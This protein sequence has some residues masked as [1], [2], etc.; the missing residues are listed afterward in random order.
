MSLGVGDMLLAQQARRPKSFAP[1]GHTQIT[2]EDFAVDKDLRFFRDHEHTLPLTHPFISEVY[3]L[4][5]DVQFRTG[6]L[7]TELN[8]EREMFVTLCETFPEMS[9]KAV[10]Y[11]LVISMNIVKYS[12]RINYIKNNVY[13]KVECAKNVLSKTP[14]FQPVSMALV[15]N[16]FPELF[17]KPETDLQMYEDY[18]F[19]KAKAKVKELVLEL[20]MKYI[21]IVRAES[22]MVIDS[23]PDILATLFDNH[24]V[25]WRSDYNPQTMSTVYTFQTESE[26]MGDYIPQAIK[27]MAEENGCTV[28]PTSSTILNAIESNS[29]VLELEIVPQALKLGGSKAKQE[30]EDQEASTPRPLKITR[31]TAF[32]DTSQGPSPLKI[33]PQ[34]WDAPLNYTPSAVMKPRVQFEGFK[35]SKEEILAIV[36]GLPDNDVEVIISLFSKISCTDYERT[37]PEIGLKHQET[38]ACIPEHLNTVVPKNGVV[39][40]SIEA[41][42]SIKELIEGIQIKKEESFFGKMFGKKAITVEETKK[43]IHLKTRDLRGKVSELEEINNIVT[44]IKV[45]LEN[46]R[47]G[48]SQNYSLIKVLKSKAKNVDILLDSRMGSLYISL[49][50]SEQTK[51][52]IQIKTKNIQSIISTIRDTL[53]TSIPSWFNQMEILE[54]MEVS[55]A[56]DENVVKALMENQENILKPLSQ[57]SKEK[58]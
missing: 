47:E 23:T 57:F 11:G 5:E 15:K 42:A 19:P 38:L 44:N 7:K 4:V 56:I 20:P 35:F 54:Q 43:M 17:I 32:E 21:I 1:A 40:G 58:A 9:P 29:K 16:T 26:K 52:L 27:L 51:Q 12:N 41:L 33:A 25:D 34:Q 8:E 46:C 30:L 3:E 50:I 2:E 31:R 6:K 18:W 10:A 13:H 53:L 48:L 37:I 45:R 39:D 22:A 14:S 49:S 28:V 36:P 55:N 24:L